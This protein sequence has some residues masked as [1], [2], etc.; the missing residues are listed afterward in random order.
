MLRNIENNLL[1]SDRDV[2]KCSYESTDVFIEPRHTWDQLL[3]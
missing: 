2:C 3:P 1:Y